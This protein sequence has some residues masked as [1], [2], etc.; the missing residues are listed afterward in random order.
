M[1]GK[2]RFGHGFWPFLCRRL[3]A[4]ILVIVGIKF[5]CVD[6]IKAHSQ[7]STLDATELQ[8]WLPAVFCFC[9]WRTMSYRE[10]LY[11]SYLS[12]NVK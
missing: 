3:E 7:R 11:C 5:C 12:A 6:I 4:D 10:K 1:L 2:Q 8:Q 9:G